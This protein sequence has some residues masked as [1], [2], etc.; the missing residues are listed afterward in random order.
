ME[1]QRGAAVPDIEE[2]TGSV[3]GSRDAAAKEVSEGQG[4]GNPE[5]QHP[6]TAQ[7]AQPTESPQP[8]EP[9]P[10]VPIPALEEIRQA[11]AD[12][13]QSFDD[14][15]AQDKHKNA[16]FD[17]MHRELVQY[18]NGVADKNTETMAMDIIQ[19]IDSTRNHIR[20]Y[21]EKEGTQENY[22][23]LLRL[24]KGLVEDLQDVLYRQSIEA[25][26]VAGE[27]VDVRRQKII[28]TLETEDPA[29]DNFIA[30]RVADGYEK[31]DK[32]LRPERIKIYKYHKKSPDADDK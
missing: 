28:Q 29:Q 3:E 16:L 25:Y 31:G 12:L 17:Q 19:L 7:K 24:V 4:Q 5:T 22:D 20:V 32:V 11:I 15:I 18:Q 26:R 23:R 14:K 21:E 1:N 13:Q 6:E 2:R 27:E 8:V 30:V 10:P 9:P